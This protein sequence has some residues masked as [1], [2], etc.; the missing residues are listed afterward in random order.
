[1][2]GKILSKTIADIITMPIRLSKDIVEAVEKAVDTE[3][4]TK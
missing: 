2:I 4:E 3:E 1:M